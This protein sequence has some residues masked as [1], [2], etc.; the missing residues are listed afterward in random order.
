MILASLIIANTII[1]EMN[2]K[3]SV[4]EVFALIIGWFVGVG[5]ILNG[6]LLVLFLIFFLSRFT[7]NKNQESI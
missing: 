3:I 2:G 6:I 4:R 1:K 7:E 5:N